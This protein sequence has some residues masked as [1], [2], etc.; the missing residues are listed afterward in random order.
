M[1]WQSLEANYTPRQDLLQSM[2]AQQQQKKPWWTSII[3]E[4]GGG[5]GAAGG[6]AAGAAIG[7]P[8]GGVGAVPGGIIG[9]ILGGFL[10]GTGGRV[11]ENKV[12]DNR[13]GIGDALKEGAVTGALSGLGE[14]YAAFKGAKAATGLIDAGASGAEKTAI[15][16]PEKVGLLEGMGRS[17]KAGAGGYGIGAKVPGEQQLTAAGSD[18]VGTTLDKLGIKAASPEAQ[19]RSIGQKIAGLNSQLTGQY[20]K[21]NASL[22]QDELNNLGSKILGRVSSA[23]GLGDSA[24]K[25]GL[26]EA[27][28]L[29]KSGDVNGLWN[30]VKDLSRNATN[31][32]TS[33]DAKLADK[34]GAA[35][36]ILDEARGFLNGKVPGLADTNNLYHNA[37]TAESFLLGAAKDKTSAGLIGTVKSLSPVK[38]AESKGFNALENIGRA[39]AGTATGPITGPASDMTRM[40]KIQAPGA[41]ARGM[42]GSQDQTQQGD[43]LSQLNS[44]GQMQSPDSLL[45]QSQQTNVN[46]LATPEGLQQAM[47]QDF[48]QTGGKNFQE[49]QALAQVFGGGQQK[50]SAAQ[51]ARKDSIN[52]ALGSLDSAE[53]N[54]GASGGA[55]GLQGEAGKIPWLG[56]FI[57]PKGASYTN[58]KVELATA[59][60]KAITGGSRAPQNV[61]D[62]YMH[63]LPDINDTPEYASAKIAKL[64]NDLVAQANRFGY[65]DILQSSDTGGSSL[66]TQLNGQG[67][68]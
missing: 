3:S 68:F 15:Q 35:R 57:D 34:E 54:L 12:R 4:L 8:L 42:S 33:G 66:L 53:Q 11:V 13:I 36:I 50:L 17:G 37:K 32:A 59:L 19:A 49:L 58:T 44:G 55:Q 67:A 10:G 46:P 9:A 52:S 62:Y 63:S 28:K 14:G 2:Q 22:T 41:I 7:A 25:F 5:G 65:S 38:G 45:G 29:V 27:Q 30:Y 43:L 26:D 24:Q 16:A 64:R 47:M 21:A 23:P 60:A 6:A 51:Q 56:K 31:F 20:S 48:V 39:S 40:L 18:A 1:D 61:I